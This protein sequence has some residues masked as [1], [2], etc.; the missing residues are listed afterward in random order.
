MC[1]NVVVSPHRERAPFPKQQ[2]HH[3]FAL[4]DNKD[5]PS[6]DVEHLHPVVVGVA[7]DDAVGVAHGDVVRVLQVAAQVAQ[8]AKLAHERSVGLED[9][10]AV[11][12]LV[13]HVDEVELIGG[14]SPRIAKLAIG[15]ALRAEHSHKAALRVEDLNSVVVAI[16]HDVVA[17]SVDRHA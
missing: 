5:R 12:V 9:L 10:N 16:G 2:Q 17:Q 15:A 6:I 7:D 14:Y 11:V 3:T 13:A 8:R 4:A 1:S